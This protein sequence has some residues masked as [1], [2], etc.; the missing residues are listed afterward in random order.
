MYLLI[1]S[2]H[3]TIVKESQKCKE[4]KVGQRI[5]EIFRYEPDREGASCESEWKQ[6][7]KE[8]GGFYVGY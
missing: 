2:F 8:Y 6:V 1:N 7:H 4:T 3:A 5:K